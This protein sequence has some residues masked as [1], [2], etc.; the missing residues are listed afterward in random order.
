[1][2]DE[3]TPP[4][5][6]ATAP[7][8]FGDLLALARQSWIGQMEQ[9]L[10][11][12]GYTG[13]QRSDATTMRLL[14]RHSP[15][16]VGRAA[17]ALGVTRQAARKII[18]NLERRGFVRTERD[19]LDTRRV[20]VVLTAAGTAYAHAVVGVIHALNRELCERVEPE[21]LAAADAVL[22]AS[23]TDEGVAARA[24]RVGRP[25]GVAGAPGAPGHG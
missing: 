7:Y 23:I 9:R 17:P 2:S 13:Y 19:A 1:M 15:V 11:A 4:Q 16:P 3:S 22:R 8:L 6:P 25:P 10:D 24:A 14:L 21:L 18:D 5:L 20:N 12:L